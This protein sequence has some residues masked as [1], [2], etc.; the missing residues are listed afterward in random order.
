MPTKL[1]ACLALFAVLL[2]SL[3]VRAETI[4][5]LAAVQIVGNVPFKDQVMAADE[6]G[7]KV[8]RLAVRWNEVEKTKG[9]FDWEATDARFNLVK[10][11][12]MTPIITL[13]G[14]ND[15]YRTSEERRMKA[16]PAAGDALAG[17]AGFSAEV[18][19]RFGNKIN[20]RTL[21]YEI[22]NEPNTKTFWNLSP[23]P[24]AYAALATKSCKAIKAITPENR[25]LGLAMEGSPVKLPYF[26]A[27]YDIDIYQQ[28]AN[29]AATPDLMAC[30]DGISMHPYREKP[31]TYLNDEPALQVFI[32]KHWNRS[33]PPIVA[34]TEWGY[35]IDL[36][37]RADAAS[38][39]SRVLRSLLIGVGMKRLTNIYQSVDTGTDENDPRMSYGLFDSGGTI[40]PSGTA[41]KT[42][43]AAVGDFEVVGLSKIEGVDHAHR[44]ELISGKRTAFVVWSSSEPVSAEAARLNLGLA[45]HGTNLLTGEAVPAPGDALLLTSTPILFTS[46]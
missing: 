32:G 23:D 14:G 37:R 46:P 27:A 28:W 40:K 24:E 11:R 22:W 35:N 8:V 18:A 10:D 13:F 33:Q 3:P 20:G 38:Q 43:L 30:V 6:V 15:L 17:F 31:E 4:Q 5:D 44:L 9:R 16:S 19:K 12:G 34:N 2:V 26:V 7:F 42:L 29:R 45:S 39:A 41:I 36:G 21:Y 1:T 25:V